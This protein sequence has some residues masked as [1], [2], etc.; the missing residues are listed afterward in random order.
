M[1]H[2]GKTVKVLVGNAF[3]HA[4]IGEAGEKAFPAGA[5][6]RNEQEVSAFPHRPGY[7]LE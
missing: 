5:V 7:S 3:L 4:S 1:F 2:A 6:N